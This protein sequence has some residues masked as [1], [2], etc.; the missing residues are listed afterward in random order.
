MLDERP[1]TVVGIMPAS[2]RIPVGGRQE[3]W[4][5]TVQDPLFST[6][7]PK[8]EEH[9]MRVVGRLN[10]RMSLGSA[11]AEADSIGARLAREFPAENGGWALHL[12]PLQEAIVADIRT[13]LLGT[14][15]TADYVSVSP[16]YFRIMGI[17]LRRGR[18]FDS[19]DSDHSPSIAIVSESFA[20][21]YFRDENPIGQ[22]LVFGFPPDS[23]V[24]REIVGVVGNVRDAG[25]TEEPGPMMYVSYAQAPFWGVNV[26]VK[27]TLPP[28][29]LV[30][31]IREVARSLG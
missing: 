22:K 23:N 21:L 27:S 4:I 12:T 2:F 11:Q 3:I 7:I 17:P 20:S 30:G 15:S 24:T 16:G 19:E 14:P 8:R 10:P 6:W 1:F 28:A 26:V 5:P 13:P 9:W 31:T 29:A 18:L 25:L